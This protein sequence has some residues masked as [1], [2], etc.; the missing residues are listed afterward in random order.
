MD[1]TVSGEASA[2]VFL[3]L[4]PLPQWRG[5]SQAVA[6]G[7]DI[8]RLAA[9]ERAAVDEADRQLLYHGIHPDAR[10]G[11]W[12]CHEFVADANSVVAQRRCD[13][14]LK[15]MLYA[16]YAI[17]ILL[18]IGA[19]NLF[20]FYRRTA[21][22]LL[23]DST[24]HRPAYGGTAW[25]HQCDVPDFLREDISALFARVEVVFRK[26]T[27]RLQI[28]IWLLEQGLIAPDRHIRILLWATGLDG[29]TRSGGIAA[30]CERLCGLLGADTLV[31]PASAHYPRPK[32]KIADVVNDLYLLRTEMA[33]G[34]PFHER[35]RKTRG[36]LAEGDVPVAAEFADW[37]YDHVLEE[38]S[39][40]LLCS[41]LREVLVRNRMFDVRA[42]CWQ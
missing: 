22:G 15:Q 35:F 14:A 29:I 8:R 9:P 13:A 26:P 39:A 33:H 17:Q 5:N 2:S 18:P 30:Y 36:F 40:F 28:P 6:P 24:Q 1:F 38:C 21:V 37:R 42:K 41:A 16:I 11:F 25:A 20:L 19:P 31:F 12:L 10:D 32:Y 27:L 4:S 34:L 7:F 23:L 3:L